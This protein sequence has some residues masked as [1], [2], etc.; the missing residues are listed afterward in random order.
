MT[1]Y[2]RVPSYTLYWLSST[3]PVGAQIPSESQQQDGPKA[4]EKNGLE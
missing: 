3:L 2:L 4:A 1:T